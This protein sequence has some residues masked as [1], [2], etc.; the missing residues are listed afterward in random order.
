MNMQ[1]SLDA[2][3]LLK[4]FEKGPLGGF[5]SNPYRCPA[6][7]LTVGWGHVIKPRE[8]FASPLTADQAEALL[9]SDLTIIV[10]HLNEYI[11][12]PITQSM[13]DALCCFAFNLGLGAM[14]GSTLLWKLNRGDYAGA[15]DEL[16]C[17]DK[18]TNPKTGKKEPLAG[19]VRRRQA[20]RELF[21][22]GGL[23]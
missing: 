22:S 2:L 10:K 11:R 14:A 6:G 20:E 1:P 18:A 21:L 12:A 5:A 9:R 15:A 13:F 17:W 3:K 23:P 4:E 16:L 19:L 8:T 7:K